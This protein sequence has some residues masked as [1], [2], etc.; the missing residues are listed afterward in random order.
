MESVQ[1]VICSRREENLDRGVKTLTAETGETILGVRA[2]VC[3]PEDCTHLIEK[4]REIYG[5]VDFLINNA[6]TYAASQF[7]NVLDED[8]KADLDLKVMGAVRF[9]RGI[10]SIMRERDC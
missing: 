9:S 5:G 4:T 7:E 6:G 3:N 10:L 8:R 2:D 1:D